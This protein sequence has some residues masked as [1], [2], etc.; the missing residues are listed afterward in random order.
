LMLE[1]CFRLCFLVR[2]SGLGFVRE[3]QLEGGAVGVVN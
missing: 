2:E 3:M 1:R